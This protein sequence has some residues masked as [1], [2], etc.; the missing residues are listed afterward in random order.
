MNQKYDIAVIG[1]GPGGYSAALFLSNRNRKVCLI[2]KDAE[3]V[4]G[5]CLNEGCIPVKSLLKTAR[6]YRDMS[7]AAEAGVL[8][9]TKGVDLKEARRLAFKAT[10]TL[11]R[12]VKSLLARA[13]VDFIEGHAVLS[14]RD[15]IKISSG[16]P[17]EREISAEKI[18]VA[19]GSK[20][21]GI[22]GVN[23]DGKRVMTSKEALGLTEVPRSLLV[24]GAGAVGAEFASLFSSF[25]SKVT[26]TEATESVLPFMDREVS[27]SLGR[28]FR[29][30]GIEVFTGT[31]LESL[32]GKGDSVE[33]VLSVS[34]D[35]K[36]AVYERVLIAVGRSPN[37]SGMGLEEAGVEMKNGFIA[38]DGNMMTSV[39]GIYAAGDVVESPMYAHT[40]FMEARMASRSI[41]GA[42]EEAIDYGAVPHAVFS[43]P[44]VASVGLTAEEALSLGLEAVSSKAFF[45]AN[46]LAVAEGR[47]EGFINVVHDKSDGRILG[48]HIIGAEATEII[49]EFVLA[50]SA[51]LSIDDVR[52]VIHA[53]PTYSEIASELY[54]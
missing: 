11:K 16:G 38:V 18:I 44:Q 37:T 7:D 41:L 40:A 27:L 6:L 42:K 29:K 35:K 49:H 4:G 25:G 33:A 28:S 48:V 53:H 45:K 14:G 13:G 8:K 21:K 54:S 32:C 51:G 43:L 2:D 46:G 19:S 20:A 47:D 30:R 10:E 24:V 34:G 3:S 9:G 52:G 17:G 26:L 50:K 36:R 15:R 22:P 31:S 23:I 5:V 1:A 39:E 12:G